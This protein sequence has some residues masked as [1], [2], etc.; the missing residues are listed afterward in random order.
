MVWLSEEGDEKPY[1]EKIIAG[2]GKHT[3]PAPVLRR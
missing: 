1:Y 2:A 3:K